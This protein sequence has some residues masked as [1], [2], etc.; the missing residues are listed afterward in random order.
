MLRFQAGIL[1][2]DGDIEWER[3][4]MV[5]RSFE[6]NSLRLAALEWPGKGLRIIALHGWLDNA[7]SF[8]PLA[9][10]LKGHH[11]LALDLPGHG[12]SDHLPASAHYHLA[13]NLHTICAVADAMGWQRFVLLGHSMGAAIATLSAAAMPQRVS[14][15]SL[16]DGLGPI[17]Y[18]PQ[19]EVARLH[20][21]FEAGAHE[22]KARPFT[23]IDTAVRIR[24]RYSRF[25]ISAEAARLMVE[26]NL[27]HTDG[28]YW[29]RYDERL[30]Q[31]SSHY[32]CE[33]QV[34]G[35]LGTINAP[36]LLLSAEEGALKGWDGF[37]ERRGAFTGL[38][39]EV[40]AGGHHL[41]MEQPRTVAERLLAF[42]GKLGGE[43]S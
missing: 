6:V 5:E 24:K 32:Y 25:A 17:A 13:D 43:L 21:L 20:Q 2:L 30:K 16:I 33:E 14:G 35:I 31:P 42:Y 10:H 41:H 9:E 12:Q 26:R 1:V 28:G 36:A 40:L 18:T 37:A 39:H 19:Q 7:A 38:Q 34:R 11:L 8:I 23:D 29:W 3:D 27:R 4:W 22:H 15:L